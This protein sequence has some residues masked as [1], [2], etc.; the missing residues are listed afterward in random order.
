MCAVRN[1]ELVS[2]ACLATFLLL[3]C[4]CCCA[5]LLIAIVLF[6]SSSR[7]MLKV[8]S[9]MSE[10]VAATF[11]HA[12]IRMCVC[13]DSLSCMFVRLFIV[14]VSVAIYIAFHGYWFCLFAFC[15][16]CYSLLRFTLSASSFYSACASRALAHLAA[17]YW[18][19][20][21]SLFAFLFEL[22]SFD[23]CFNPGCVCGC[24]LVWLIV[25]CIVCNGTNADD[26]LLLSPH[27]YVLAL[28]STSLSKKIVCASALTIQ[29]QTNS[30]NWEE[31]I[32]PS[33]PRPTNVVCVLVH[34][35]KCWNK[36]KENV[37]WALKLHR[38]TSIP[39]FNLRQCMRATHTHR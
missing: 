12:T 17:L 38:N 36:C 13:I 23:C 4:R 29:L 31:K 34:K 18:R 33:P 28:A 26:E 27:F 37:G 5:P 8:H 1:C 20:R 15:R 22:C 11:S 6:C 24:V 35:L 9:E 39:F 32:A 30:G 3:R 10:M 19:F 25:E 7:R 2:R 16:H 14:I 21:F